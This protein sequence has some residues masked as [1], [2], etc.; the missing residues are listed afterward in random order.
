MRPFIPPPLKIVVQKLD[1]VDDRP[2]KHELTPEDIRN[3]SCYQMLARRNAVLERRER[4]IALVV[5]IA[6]VVVTAL[7][8]F[9]IT[10]MAR[11][12]DLSSYRLP[13]VWTNASTSTPLPQ[14]AQ[15]VA[16]PASVAQ[17]SPAPTNAP[18]AVAITPTAT[19]VAPTAPASADTKPI[20]DT[21]PATQPADA[22]NQLAAAIRALI[23]QQ[24]VK[25]AGQVE[26]TAPAS[27]KPITLIPGINTVKPSPAPAQPPAA[28]QTPPAKA[29]LP[30]QESAPVKPLMPLSILDFLG[31]N[32]AVLLSSDGGQTMRTYRLGDALPTG[33]VIKAID[34]GN[35][36]IT[37][38]QR[39]IK[40]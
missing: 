9:V 18:A 22:A 21:K 5:L 3:E 17:P 4:H 40:K 16:R 39:I 36:S 34:S 12:L 35:G 32:T 27:A 20:G 24:P 29:T 30:V 23:D 1:G 19:P 2:F 25:P 15:A 11:N 14:P 26:S 7:N 31:T 6:A 33:E 8:A 28:P 10:P 13:W 37:T 38:N